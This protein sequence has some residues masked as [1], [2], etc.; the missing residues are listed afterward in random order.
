MIACTGKDYA[1]EAEFIESLIRRNIKIPYPTVLDLGCGT[2]THAAMLIKRGFNVIGGDISKEMLAI[3]K[4][5][6]SMPCYRIDM[7]AFLLKKKVDTIICLYNTIMYNRTEKELE[8]TFGSCCN[9]LNRKGIFI[10]Q[11]T[12]PS[13]LKKAKDSAYIWDLNSEEKI[14]QSSFIRYPR[15]VQNFVFL[16]LKTGDYAVDTHFMTIFSLRTIKS[17]LK[18]A[19]F[20]SIKSVKKGTT[21]YVC[22]KKM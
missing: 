3:A 13:V 17:K 10:I 19:G 18:L 5:K 15:F 22:C 6:T 8:S 4:K 14:I 16:N 7:R 11:L 20:S 12:N 9:S 1:S 2:G 21:V